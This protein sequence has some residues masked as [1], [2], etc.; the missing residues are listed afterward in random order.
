MIRCKNFIN[1]ANVRRRAIKPENRVRRQFKEALGLT[2][3]TYTSF[4]ISRFSTAIFSNL[5][6]GY[7]YYT[8]RVGLSASARS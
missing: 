2:V 4:F 7:Y 5:G 1:Q 6:C 3:V 8:G